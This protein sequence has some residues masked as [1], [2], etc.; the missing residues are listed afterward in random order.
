MIHELDPHHPTT[1]TT[2]GLSMQ[3]AK[4]IRKRAPD[5][6]FLSVQLYGGL[7]GFT[8]ALREIHHRGPMMITE[9]GTSG[10]WEVPTTRWDAPIEMTST[11]KAE[12]YIKGFVEEIHTLDERL[13]GNYVFLWSYK[14]ERTP[15][16]YS[17]FTQDGL[18]TEVVDVMQRIWTGAWPANRAPRVEQLRFAHT[19]SSSNVRLRAG[20]EYQV[21]VSAL[22]PEN[23]PLRYEW[24]LSR[25]SD[26]TEIG[27][28]AEAVPEDLTA[29]LAGSDRPAVKF[30]TPEDAGAYRLFVYVYDDA[31]G[32]AHA[33]VPFFV[34]AGRRSGK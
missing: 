14:L 5:L 26:A 20:D 25:E 17:M 10:H 8:E 11:E 31:G 13:I 34:K 9:W 30:S 4:R 28:D 3:L 15:T 19:G 2:A 23:R 7:F 22:D 29:R 6:D 32:V 18:R 21:E 27:G 16:W 24:R 12:A 1:T 33:N